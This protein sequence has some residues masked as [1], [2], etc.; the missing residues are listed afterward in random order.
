MGC[1]V[2]LTEMFH[3]QRLDVVIGVCDVTHHIVDDGLG[4]ILCDELCLE[5]FPQRVRSQIVPVLS[6]LQ[7]AYPENRPV[8]DF[9]DLL[10]A[11]GPGL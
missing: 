9:V 6:R 4:D 1:C 7:E 8:N 10:F 5:E 3:A 2:E 11:Y